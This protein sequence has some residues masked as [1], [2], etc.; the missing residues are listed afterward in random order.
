MKIIIGFI[1][2][3]LVAGAVAEER[4]GSGPAPATIDMATSG[5]LVVGQSPTKKRTVIQ[6]DEDGYAICSDLR[7]PLK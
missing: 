2:G 6:T 4:R 1:I 5:W 3:V 7:Q